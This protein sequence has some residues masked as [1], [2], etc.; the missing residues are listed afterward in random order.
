MWKVK[1]I[2]A[3]SDLAELPLEARLDMIASS[4]KR[5]RL[6]LHCCCAPCTSYVLECLSPF[7]EIT[8]FFYNPNIDSGE[9]YDKRANEFKKLPLADGYLDTIGVHVC[10]YDP[11]T[12]L[13]MATP[14]KN[15][16]EGGV[17]CRFCF[18]FRLEA[19]AKFAKKHGFDYF[20]TTLSVSPHKNAA[21]LNELGGK[22]AGVHAVSYLS[23]D[24]KKRGGYLRSV[25]LS[26]QYGL[27]RQSY[28]GCK[29]G[30]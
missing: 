4:G 8:L 15:E 10:Q 23:A 13:S 20:T 24:F 6:L 21:L 26:R 27:Y 3:H 7:F 9:E 11:D 2:L 12:F 28:C 14:M 16:P 30:K 19:T 5:P 1:S 17:R 18:E 22:T 25:E 29:M